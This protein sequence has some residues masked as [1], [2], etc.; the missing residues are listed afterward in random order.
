MLMIVG[1]IMMPRMMEAARTE[2]PG[3]AEGLADERHQDDDADEP[4]DDRGDA[5]QELD[6]RLDDP[7]DALRGEL[8]QDD[9]AGQAEGDAEDHGP[10]GDVDRADDHR[11][12]P[13]DLF[14][15]IPFPPGQEALQAVLEHDRRALLD[16][17]YGDDEKDRHGREGDDQ[18][19]QPDEPVVA[20][21]PV[22]SGLI[23]QAFIAARPIT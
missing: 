23:R 16:D 17:E 11:P 4:V 21:E 14:G 7:P 13:E 2:R 5:G 8:R 6:H 18:E 9:G 12:E 3:P 19:G 1:R 22:L 10:Q 20:F 15:G